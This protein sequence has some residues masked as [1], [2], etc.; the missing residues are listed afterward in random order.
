MKGRHL[1][2]WKKFKFA[3]PILETGFAEKTEA[4]TSYL[5]KFENPALSGNDEARI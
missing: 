1:L 2:S 3:Y 4:I 5:K